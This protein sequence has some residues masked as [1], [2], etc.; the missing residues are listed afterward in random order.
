MRDIKKVTPSGLFLFLAALVLA[1]I[2]VLFLPI[3]LLPQVLFP[4]TYAWVILTIFVIYKL[5]GRNLLNKLLSIFWI[6]WFIFPFLLY[7]AI[8]LLWSVVPDISV[9]RWLTLVCVIVIS[10]YIGIQYNLNQIADVLDK[11][12]AYVLMLSIVVVFSVPVVGIMNYHSIQGAWKGLFWHKNHMGLLACFFC[13]LFF[14]KILESYKQ[15]IKEFIIWCLLYLISLILIY[16][17]DSVA[18]YMTFILVHGFIF[19]MS[20]YLKYKN[21][22][23]KLHYIIFLLILG[24]MGLAVFSNADIVLGLFN[25]KTN[26]TGRV[27]MWMHLFDLYLSKRPL[28]GY[29]FN[30]F[31]YVLSHEVV[32]GIVAHYPDPIIISDNGFIDILMNGGFVGLSLFTLFYLG[33]W[34]QVIKFSGKARVISDFLPLIIMVYIFLAN[35][36]WSLLFENEGTFMLI[37][38]VVSFSISSSGR[39]MTTDTMLET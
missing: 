5:I 13:I 19:L 27:P 36:T 12:G 2:P 18:A 22:L 37:M 11:F 23:N 33:V 8:S 10:G 6:N 38:L 17:S 21:K 9:A 1:N 24:V 4:V 39:K 30:A 34:V 26:L 29:G 25:R 7:S 28:I 14:V 32:M 3:W 20:G 35:L 15:N 16:K 31:W